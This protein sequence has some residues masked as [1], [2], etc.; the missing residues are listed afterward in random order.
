MA[1]PV[2]EATNTSIE[3]VA[4]TSHV[5]ALPAGIVSGNLLLV[6]FASANGDSGT[7]TPTG[8]TKYQDYD[9]GA[10]IT[11]VSFYRQADGGEGVTLTV[12]T[13]ASVQS[14]HNS[15]RI[16][17]HVNPATQA[18]QV[19][20]LTVGNDT[21]PDCLAL[22]PTGGAKD[23]LW[24]P[25]T[26]G[27]DA[28]ITAAPTNYTNLLNAAGASNAHCG[29]A[30]RE[31]NAASEDP[32]AFTAGATV[33]WGAAVTVVHPAVA[34]AGVWGWRTGWRWAQARARGH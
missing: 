22:T 32:G 15:Y 11:A 16:S 1:F 9:A 24:I 13:T 29:S 25:V 30:R 23:Y 12:T 4:T 34:A 17:G 6:H 14:A 21:A 7:G 31:L 3:S 10:T 5:V 20:A 18:P 19:G 2:V 26:Y 28:E 8:W 33:F 27:R